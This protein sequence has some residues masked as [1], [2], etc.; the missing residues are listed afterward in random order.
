MINLT[1]RWTWVSYTP[2]A[3]GKLICNVIQQSKDF[4]NWYDVSTDK[5]KNYSAKVMPSKLHLHLQKEIQNDY[6]LFWYTRELPYTRGD[7]LKVNEVNKLISSHNNNLINKRIVTPW[8]KPYYP[9]WFAGSIVQIVNDKNSVEFL[10]QRR[11]QLFYKWVS[12]NKVKCLRYNT[13]HMNK[14]HV[15]FFKSFDDAPSPYVKYNNK[16]DYWDQEF[17]NNVEVTKFKRKIKHQN[18]LCVIKLSDIINDNQNKIINNLE[19]GLNI[20]IDRTRAKIIF[21]SWQ[22]QNK[23]FF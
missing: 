12:K 16:H 15:K 6:K 17:Y 1:S 2:G 8:T 11:D 14:S 9:D 21:D 19:T 13:D 7:N 5:L 23:K 20:T 18:L 10:K 4:D 22:E 3:S